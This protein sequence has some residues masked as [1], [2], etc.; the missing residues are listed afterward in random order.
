MRLKYKVLIIS[1]IIVCLMNVTRIF[2]DDSNT[3]IHGIYALESYEQLKEFYRNRTLNT[4]DSI[5]F[6]WAKAENRDG[7]IGIYLDSKDFYLPKG[8]DESLNMTES[9]GVKKH[10]MIFANKDLEVVLENY[11]VLI[12]QISQLVNNENE[13]Y[14]KLTFDGVTIDFEFVNQENQGLFCDFLRE[15]KK[16]L[17]DK[18]LFVALPPVKNFSYYNYEC[19]GDIADYLV[20]M[21]HDFDDKVLAKGYVG[22]S[23]VKTPLTPIQKIDE[24]LTIL[25]KRIGN[26]IKKVLLQISFDTTQ[27]GVKDAYLH[28]VI[29]EA[30]VVRP[31]NPTY[32][33][34]YDRILMENEKRSYEDIITYDNIY[35]NPY[36]SYYNEA[37][38]ITY[39][40]WYEN[41]D[42][43]QSK[44]ELIKKYELAG[45]SIWRIGNIP[46]FNSIK[47]KEIK[48]DIWDIILKLNMVIE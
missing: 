21:E 24:D 29:P 48:M 13:D 4:F 47:G 12:P 17:G 26:N 10:L 40:I 33:M 36:I 3:Y 43:I 2:A 28:T 25:K 45:V 14:T 7:E 41:A 19:I 8:Y 44:L 16:T 34:I 39:Y 30:E 15:L 9:R 37:L 46:N 31:N 1:I 22:D 32:E 18:P 35:K 23:I 11:T 5:S 6:G 27:W 42:S 20:L 38:D